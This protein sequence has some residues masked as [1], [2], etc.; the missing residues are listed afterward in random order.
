MGFSSEVY[1]SCSLSTK[2]CLILNTLNTFYHFPS[3]TP[4]RIVLLCD[5]YTARLIETNIGSF[6]L[7]G[8][9][10][11]FSLEL[12]DLSQFIYYTVP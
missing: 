5:Q 12:S 2:H 7:E 9:A 3:A 8:K 10:V 1:D 4:C 11:G 6:N